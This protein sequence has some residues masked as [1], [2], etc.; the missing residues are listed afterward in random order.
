[1]HLALLLHVQSRS[2]RDQAHQV[3]ADA[4]AV[5]SVVRA[6]TNASHEKR[7]LFVNVLTQH[8]GL[9]QNAGQ[10]NAQSLAK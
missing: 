7:R 9:R 3:L 5:V 1:M 2:A 4:A 6:V 8:W 10:A